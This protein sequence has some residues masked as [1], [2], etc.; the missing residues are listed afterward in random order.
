MC[1][2]HYQRWRKNGDPLAVKIWP[3]E[4]IVEGCSDK[5]RSHGWC[6]KHYQRWVKHG[7]PVK[8]VRGIGGVWNKQG[9]LQTS[10]PG[11][12]YILVHRLVMEQELGRP[13]E[14]IENV[15][16]VNGIKHDNRPEN[17][18]LWV[19]SQPSGQRVDDLVQW[20]VEHYPDLT[21]K[22]LEGVTTYANVTQRQP[23]G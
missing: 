15:H 5:P 8:L 14:G 20:V 17:L 18:E 9:Y 7:D 19:T 12:G 2:T 4:C 3:T 13:L 23:E 21:R 22:L 11:R 16:H 10:V 6:S 1:S